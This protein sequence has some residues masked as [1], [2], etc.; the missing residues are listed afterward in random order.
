[1]EAMTRRGLWAYLA[2]AAAT[3]SAPALAE[4]GCGPD[5]LALWRQE[6]TRLLKRS[7]DAW[8]AAKAAY[9]R[10]PQEL[11]APARVKVGEYHESPVDPATGIGVA[12][13]PI[14]AMSEEEIRSSYRAVIRISTG[15]E[16]LRWV[17]TCE[18]KVAELEQAQRDRRAALDESE[19]G[20]LAA[21][22]D[23]IDAEMEE[24]Q[25]RVM[26]TIAGDGA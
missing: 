19:Y 14:F 7:D 22:A 2:G 10:L 3:V 9:D 24:F 20:R 5:Q 15:A 16:Q 6:Y 25:Q 26:A 8:A 23:A 12:S 21:E 18:A 1:M 13:Y 17:R 4:A 11:R